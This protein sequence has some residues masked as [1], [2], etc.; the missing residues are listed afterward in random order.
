[1]RNEEANPHLLDNP[2]VQPVPP[3]DQPDL[4]SLPE[5][6]SSR[7][8][9]EP[10]PRAP[11]KPHGSSRIDRMRVSDT[12][13][14]RRPPLALQPA[15]SDADG[16]SMRSMLRR[17]P[18]TDAVSPLRSNRAPSM[19]YYNP[20]ESVLGVQPAQPPQE[21][22][23]LAAA[24]AASLESVET[25]EA[26]RAG[27]DI[28]VSGTGYGEEDAVMLFDDEE[29]EQE[30]QVVENEAGLEVQT[31]RSTE[32]PKGGAG[33]RT[34]RGVDEEEAQIRLAMEM[35]LAEQQTND[36]DL[37]AVAVADVEA[38][39]EAE[40]AAEPVVD[41]CSP[42]EGEGAPSG[43]ASRFFAAIDAAAT[44][45]Q[46]QAV[47]EEGADEGRTRYRLCATVWHAGAHA[48]SGHYIADVRRD[49]RA[50]PA[51]GGAAAAV[52]REKGGKEEWQRF[53]DSY[54]RPVN[55]DAPEATNKG[56]IFFY[57]HESLLC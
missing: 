19:S 12:S 45:A 52:A 37:S 13:P 2:F 28:P 47:E 1:M 15:A 10:S 43:R 29:E 48:S 22:D 32:K 9:G 3:S 46:P 18:R 55:G 7:K 16:L 49:S 20:S 53:D 54:V 57:V 23:D 17:P 38:L 6:L 35:S 27:A 26:R 33:G 40:A 42:T 24:I 50:A 14:F 30:V 21:D 34:P 8:S 25:D 31:V 51:A 39:A 5:P 11:H 56:Y 4:S 41:L 44:D 36:K